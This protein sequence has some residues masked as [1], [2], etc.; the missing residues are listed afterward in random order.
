MAATVADVIVM[1]E[2]R[3]PWKSLRSIATDCGISYRRLDH[4][5]RLGVFAPLGL[6]VSPGSGGR[7]DWS[8]VADVLPLIAGAERELE[9]VG[10]SLTVGLVATIVDRFADGRPAVLAIHWKKDPDADPE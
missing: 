4:W 6:D 8:L 5:T 1:A 10:S 3:A 7:R 2:R 9:D